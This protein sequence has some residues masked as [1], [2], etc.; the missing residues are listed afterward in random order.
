MNY[1]EYNHQLNLSDDL[2]EKTLAGVRSEISKHNQIQRKKK[3]AYLSFAA[4]FVILAG[5]ISAVK[6]FNK[7][8]SDTIETTHNSSTNNTSVSADNST[9]EIKTDYTKYPQKIIIDNKIYSQYYFGDEKADKEN[10][11][12]LKQS[13]IGELIYT[14]DCANLTND[15]TSFEPMNIEE[16][17]SNKFYQAKIYKYAS[18]KSDNLIIINAKNEYY[19]FY[20]NGLMNDYTVEDLFNVYTAESDN[21]IIGIEIWQNELYDY[22]IKLPEAEDITGQEVRPMLRGVIKDKDTIKLITDILKKNNGESRDGLGEDLTKDKKEFTSEESLMSDYGEYE[23]RFIFADGREL[24][25]DN[26]SL[27]ISL[28]KDY[29]YFN[30]CHKGDL[31]CYAL[32]DTEYNRLAELIESSLS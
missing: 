25:L 27:D 30:I 15:L 23:L 12:E 6:Y 2:Y 16:A 32:E 19:I 21:E 18:A 20:L 17:K 26:I 7:N 22:T 11:I 8:S 9:V 3:S 14:V 13:Q 29:F 5:S 31:I 28:K 4:C 24:N 10:N 1:N